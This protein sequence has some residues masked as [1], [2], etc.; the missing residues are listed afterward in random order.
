[1]TLI[2][3]TQPL[4]ADEDR[5]AFEKLVKK[6]FSQRRKM[7]FKLLKGEFPT[8]HLE[9]AFAASGLSPTIRAEKV[10]LEQFV[11]L[12]QLLKGREPSVKSHE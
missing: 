7:M 11:R 1:M 10:S 6:S 2:R 12:T 9:T 8:D 4:L 3:R 5:G